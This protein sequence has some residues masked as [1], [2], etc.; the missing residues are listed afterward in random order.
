MTPDE[1]DNPALLNASRRR[2]ISK[3]SGQPVSAINNLIKR[4]EEVK[5]MMKQYN[6]GGFKGKM[7][8]PF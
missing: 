4:Y 2:R 7:G 3:G 6:K 5:K 8:L 1:R